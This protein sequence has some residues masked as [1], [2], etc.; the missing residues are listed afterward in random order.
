MEPV[1]PT[2]DVQ[3]SVPLVDTTR[4]VEEIV[5]KDTSVIQ[6]DPVTQ[7]IYYNFDETVVSDTVGDRMKM[8]PT[9]TRLKVTIGALSVNDVQVQSSVPLLPDGT[10]PSIPPSTITVPGVQAG[11]GGAFESITF[12]TGI[13]QLTVTNDLPIDI[14]FPNPITLTD[15]TG[16]TIASFSIAGILAGNGG[17][18]GDTSDLAGRSMDS[19]I[20]VSSAPTLDSIS[21]ATPGSPTQVIIDS[22]HRVRLELRFTNITVSN[23]TANI[24]SQS[25]FVQD[26]TLFEADDSTF[27]QSAYFKSGN[28]SIDLKNHV[29]LIVRARLRMPQ[30][31]KDLPPPLD[32]VFDT[33]VVLQPFDS[34]SVPVDLTRYRAESLT[35]TPTR[36]LIYTAVLDSVRG[37]P[38]TVN[39]DDSLTAVVN[40]A[41]G[42]EF[43]LRS[44]QVA[45]EPTFL[46]TDTSYQLSL[47]DLPSKFTV[48]SLRMPDAAFILDSMFTPVESRVSNL[49]AVVKGTNVVD[50]VRFN[51]TPPGND[52][53]TLLPNVPNQI[54]MND[55]NS[56]IFQVLNQFVA[57]ARELPDSVRVIGSALLN[58][59]YDT[60]VARLIADTT[61]ITGKFDVLFPL[62]IGLKNG[63]FRD[64]ID[65]ADKLNLSPD[66]ISHLIRAT[67]TV[68]V[69]N[70][71]PASLGLV[72]VTLDANKDSTWTLPR[73]GPININAAG[74]GSNGFSN[75]SALSVITIPI[76]RTD[77]EKLADA[78]FLR[79]AVT[80]NTSPTAPSVKFRTT[81][82]MKITVF[83]TLI[84]RVSFD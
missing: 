31:F 54:V 51:P 46:D 19:T 66:D 39:R 10:Y 64:T 15:G 49:R 42:T 57:T 58:P 4:N 78:T 40:I 68:R 37:S 72:F 13:A 50:T 28:F 62:N 61:R 47:G 8:L 18:S 83:G 65:I 84:Y 67:L 73:T 53:F 60:T 59:N 70:S 2:W 43:I 75:Q 14:S 16:D 17:I 80:L 36:H 24:P 69:H 56:T 30:L 81:D 20:R 21:I 35:Q 25:V 32:V 44:A 5:E 27:V 26:S 82:S 11:S 55:A 33:A 76:D 12:E 71:V 1:A 6:R 74:V 45:I 34:T 48:D 38:A 22:T 29:G 63:T 79:M 23:A 77:V 3:L 7:L 52:V 9:S 41:P